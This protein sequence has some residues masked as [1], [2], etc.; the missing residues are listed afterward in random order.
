MFSQ[1]LRIDFFLLLDKKTDMVTESIT[2]FL[3]KLYNDTIHKQN[4]PGTKILGVRRIKQMKI[5]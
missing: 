2:V 3:S 4:S 1:V 5:I